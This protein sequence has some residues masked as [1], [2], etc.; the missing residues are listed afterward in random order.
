VTRL[1]VSVRDVAEAR[2]ALEVGVDLLDLKEPTRGPLGAVDV[3]TVREVVEFVA[4]RTPVSV[5]LGE[6]L[7]L[8]D[9]PRG[10]LA[11]SHGVRYFK[12]GLADCTLDPDWVARW[13]NVVDAIPPSAAPVAVV[14][15][16]GASVAAPGIEVVLEAASFVGCRAVL[17]DTAIKDGRGLLDHW[18]PALLR[19]F[20]AEARG[21]GLITVIGGGLTLD[22][23]PLAAECSP[24]YV[25]VRG[26]ACSGPRTGA[27][28]A[29]RLRAVQDCLTSVSAT[30]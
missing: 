28:S 10:S 8:A 2:T 30:R 3:S 15:A 17:V 9:A 22:T 27:L 5:A 29:E 4:G 18:S 6:L 26:A 7:D 19:R 24:D 21:R 11:I 14:Y 13:K 12:L 16:D 25:A 23:I 1:L 20:L